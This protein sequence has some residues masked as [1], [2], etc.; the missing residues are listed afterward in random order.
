MVGLTPL[1]GWNRGQANSSLGSGPEVTCT[2]ENVISMDYMVY[3]NF[4]GCVLP[5]LVLM[6]L[7]YVEIFYLLH[8][9]LNK[10][11]KYLKC[12]LLWSSTHLELHMTPY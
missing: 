2:F 7:I 3:F 6:L 9:H 11:V 8:K 1:L 10:K 5:P 4:L 12:D